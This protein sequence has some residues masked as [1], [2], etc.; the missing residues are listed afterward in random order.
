MSR[1]KLRSTVGLLFLLCA[2]SS[3]LSGCSI[4]YRISQ[5]KEGR[6]V[7][8]N[9]VLENFKKA[10]YWSKPQELSKFMEDGRKT[11]LLRG[12]KEQQKGEKLVS[13]EIGDIEI[14]DDL[15]HASVEMLVK[16]FRVPN[17]VVETRREMQE[18]NFSVVFG[19]WKIESRQVLGNIPEE[20]GLA[21][22]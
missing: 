5:G 17:Y 21:V 7:S 9:E 1:S 14:H 22:P 13:I 18:W 12:F 3:T 15:N 16:Y 8:L 20:R 19:T 11:E 2:L 6:L 10:M 4:L